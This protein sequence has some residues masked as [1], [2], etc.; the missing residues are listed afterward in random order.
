MTIFQLR[1]WENEEESGNPEHG[2]CLE[3]TKLTL[4]KERFAHIQLVLRETRGSLST[5]FSDSLC[6]CFPSL[7]CKAKFALLL[8]KD[9]WKYILL[10][11]NWL[12]TI[13]FCNRNVL[14]IFVVTS[15]W[16]LYLN[17]NRDQRWGWL[18]DDFGDGELR[19]Q[20]WR[21][22]NDDGLFMIG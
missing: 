18:Q 5:I 2:F 6:G 7:S 12:E 9:E 10:L 22:K 8:L 14:I 4:I 11:I 21:F 1:L 16:S 3:R 19:I 13:Q 15:L 20:D 17:E